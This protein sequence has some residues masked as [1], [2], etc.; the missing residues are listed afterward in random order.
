MSQS[1]I[2]GTRGSG[3]DNHERRGTVTGIVAQQARHKVEAIS[4]ERHRG[5]EWRG[6]LVRVTF[7]VRVTRSLEPATF[8]ILSGAEP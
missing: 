8:T 2:G 7:R 4:R 1:E 6:R 5:E 3:G